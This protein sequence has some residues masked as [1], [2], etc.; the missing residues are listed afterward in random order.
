MLLGMRSEIA[1]LGSPTTGRPRFRAIASPIWL[2]IFAASG[3]LFASRRRRSQSV[4][5]APRRRAARICS[6]LFTLIYE[7]LRIVRFV[8]HGY[9]IYVYAEWQRR[10]KSASPGS[11]DVPD[12]QPLQHHVVTQPPDPDRMPA[13]RHRSGIE[14]QPHVVVDD[15]VIPALHTGRVGSATGGFEV[16]H[17]RG[18]WTVI[19]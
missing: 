15:R 6:L 11:V 16:G 14:R 9:R 7:P 5:L 2:F 17:Q 10:R 18:H 8:N 13:S 4:R 12:F 1:V 19:E 3:A